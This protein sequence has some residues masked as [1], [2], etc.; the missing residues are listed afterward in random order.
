[1]LY[2][3]SS[4]SQN[5]TFVLVSSGD[6]VCIFRGFVAHAAQHVSGI[7]GQQGLFLQA[8]CYVLAIANPSS[9]RKELYS[10]KEMQQASRNLHEPKS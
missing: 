7:C 4:I 5:R 10:S 3:T 8:L 1:M 6:G 2:C 9:V